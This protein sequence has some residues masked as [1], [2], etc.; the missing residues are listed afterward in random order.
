MPYC[1]ACGDWMEEETFDRLCDEC[2]Y[3]D[4]DADD[5]Y[6]EEEDDW[7]ED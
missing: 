7:E 2:F 3:E 4:D 5:F 6:D 1:K